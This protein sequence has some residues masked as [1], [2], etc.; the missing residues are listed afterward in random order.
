MQRQRQKTLRRQA[1][2][3]RPNNLSDQLQ[4]HSRQLQRLVGVRMIAVD[5]G[6]NPLHP[7]A[8][9]GQRDLLNLSLRIF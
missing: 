1:R 8:I 5:I 9:V 3:A 2:L 7:G 4:E 6:H